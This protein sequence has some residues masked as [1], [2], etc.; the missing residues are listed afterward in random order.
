MSATSRSWI[1][2]RRTSV[3]VSGEGCSRR[4]RSWSGT[5]WI[6]GRA[7][8][9][10]AM[11]A[12]SAG[13]ATGGRPRAGRGRLPPGQL[14]ATRPSHTSARTP[15]GISR[16][17]HGELR[18]E[19]GRRARHDVAVQQLHERVAHVEA[20]APCGVEPHRV[21][22]PGTE[23]A[24]RPV[25]DVAVENASTG[26]S[27]A[28]ATS[29]MPRQLPRPPSTSSWSARATIVPVRAAIASARLAV[30]PTTVGFVSCTRAPGTVPA[31]R[32]RR[33]RDRAVGRPVVRDHQ[34]VGRT[35]LRPRCS[36]AARRDGPRRRARS[37]RPRGWP[38]SA[39]HHPVDRR[40]HIGDVAI[41]QEAGSTATRPCARRS[42]GRSGTGSA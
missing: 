38:R 9:D 16:R 37:V 25:V 41:G 6:A 10:R 36:R 15:A 28:R 5:A 3:D 34:L 2:S 27:G 7:R 20:G 40:D 12:R 39:R 26:S 22:D 32:T 42:S 1:A 11:P 30:A 31:P 21:P 33:F 35:G 19:H 24:E 23:G 18:P 17:D 29:S 4:A 13:R 8:A 14:A